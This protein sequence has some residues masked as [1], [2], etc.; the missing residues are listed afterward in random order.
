MSLLRVPY[1]N[2][3]LK[4]GMSYCWL[5]RN[6]APVDRYLSLSHDLQGF[7]TSQVVSR[8][9]S[10]NSIWVFP[11]IGLPQNGLFIMENPIKMDDLEVPLFS[12][13]IHIRLFCCWMLNLTKLSWPGLES[14]VRTPGALH[15]AAS[16]WSAAGWAP[17]RKSGFLE[18]MEPRVGGFHPV[19]GVVNWSGLDVQGFL[20]VA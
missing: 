6:P 2:Q 10:I 11:K 5:V 18:G 14:W 16:A 12:G 15:G 3:P 7:Y 1:M 17:F 9:S 8:I 20:K 19:V 4:S 13:N